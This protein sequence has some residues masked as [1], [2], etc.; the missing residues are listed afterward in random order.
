MHVHTIGPSDSCSYNSSVVRHGS[1]FIQPPWEKELLEKQ[2]IK[3]LYFFKKGEHSC[4]LFIAMSAFGDYFIKSSFACKFDFPKCMNVRV[5]RPIVNL[6]VIRWCRL[7]WN[8][9]QRWSQTSILVILRIFPS[10][11]HPSFVILIIYCFPFSSSS[12]ATECCSLISLEPP[13][14]K[15]KNTLFY[16]LFPSV[17]Q[18]P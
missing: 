18:V 17:S 13:N 7:V 8:S 3:S 11:L 9:F 14:P 16:E 2:A 12:A 6:I 5:I 4:Y 1:V 15:I 10:N